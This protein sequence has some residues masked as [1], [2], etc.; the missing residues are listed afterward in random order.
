MG[1]VKFSTDSTYCRVAYQKINYVL[2][3]AIMNFKKNHLI[4]ENREDKDEYEERLVIGKSVPFAYFVFV[5]GIKSVTKFNHFDRSR[6]F[7]NVCVGTMF[8]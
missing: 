4:D 2:V 8:V 7:R 3:I 6:R 1:Y 5:H